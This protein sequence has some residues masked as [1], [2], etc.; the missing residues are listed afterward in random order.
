MR[1]EAPW[2][3]PSP[4]PFLDLALG[5]YLYP[6]DACART[7]FITAQAAARHM[8]R[9]QSGV[10]LTLSTPGARMA[11]PG[12]LGYCMTCAAI[13]IFTRVLAAELGPDGVGQTAVFLA[14]DHAGAMTGTV[15]NLSCGA[16]FD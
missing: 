5:E 15:A 13:E 12:V 9:Q 6:I 2:R 1:W 4:P 8:A 3:K 16:V 14:C 7:N 10:I 11:A